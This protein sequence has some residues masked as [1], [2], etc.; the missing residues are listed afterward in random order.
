MKKKKEKFRKKV[1]EMLNK[2]NEWY[3]KIMN[4][5]TKKIEIIFPFFDFL[6]T[7]ERKIIEHFEERSSEYQRVL[8]D[9]NLRSDFNV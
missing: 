3:Q 1:K 5:F 4:D 6:D 8:D 2:P 7:D 9:L